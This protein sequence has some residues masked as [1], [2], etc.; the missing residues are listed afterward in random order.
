[1]LDLDR[2]ALLLEFFF[3]QPVRKGDFE[4]VLPTSVCSALIECGLMKESGDSFI[5]DGC[6]V[7]PWEGNYLFAPQMF[8]P[9]THPWFYIGSDSLRLCR[10]TQYLSNGGTVFEIGVGTGI[11]GLV[12]SRGQYWGSEVDLRTT[13]VAAVNFALNRQTARCEVIHGDLFDGCPAGTVDLMAA[14]PPYLPEP[15]GISLPRFVGGGSTGL[16]VVRRIF[17]ALE[18]RANSFR[19]CVVVLRAFG[20]RSS[21]PLERELE[22]FAHTWGVEIYYTGRRRVR[23]ADFR[24]LAQ[25]FGD[26]DTASESFATHFQRSDFLYQ[27]DATVIVTRALLSRLRIL[28]LYDFWEDESVPVPIRNVKP[29]ELPKREMDGSATEILKLID[30]RLTVSQIAER[31]LEGPEFIDARID[32]VLAQCRKMQSQ[33]LLKIG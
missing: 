13:F 18:D 30:G 22:P 25:A 27:F 28:H 26:A 21:T 32:F 9:G 19:R 15:D 7:V 2:R 16:D 1:M 6:C 23:Y 10:A 20:S 14:N 4:R 24:A 12:G 31:L 11:V 33:G 17:R 29:D 5:M 3:G 8:F